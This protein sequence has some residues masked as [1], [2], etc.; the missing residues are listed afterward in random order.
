MI[1]SIITFFTS[2]LVFKFLMP[3]CCSFL[4]SQSVLHRRGW[5]LSSW[6]SVSPS[7]C[8]FLS[9]LAS[10]DRTAVLLQSYRVCAAV[11]MPPVTADGRISWCHQ[12][13]GAKRKHIF[14]LTASFMGGTSTLRFAGNC[15]FSSSLSL[16]HTHAHIHLQ[17]HKHTICMWA[18]IIYVCVLFDCNDF[19]FCFT[20]SYMVILLL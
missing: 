11:A 8:L 20:A 15:C 16:S 2:M 1:K 5:T 13:Y 17:A 4:C 9:E 6:Q 14:F 7:F 10:Q 3:L 18:F 19:V 12:S